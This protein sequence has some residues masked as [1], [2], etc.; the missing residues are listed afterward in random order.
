MVISVTGKKS[1]L[2]YS[3]RCL[4]KGE[5]LVQSIYSYPQYFITFANKLQQPIAGCWDDKLDILNV[6][7]F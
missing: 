6:K 3:N 7:G 1:Q 5:A 4:Y 2:S